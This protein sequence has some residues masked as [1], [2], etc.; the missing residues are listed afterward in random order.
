MGYFNR[1]GWLVELGIVER[2]PMRLPAAAAAAGPPVWRVVYATQMGAAETL[3]HETAEHIRQA[4]AEARVLA[5][6][7]LTAAS[8]ASAQ[9][10][11]LIASTTY[12]GDPPDMAEDFAAHAMRQPAQLAGLRF[13][14]LALGDRAYADFCAFGR[15]LHQWLLASGAQPLFAPIEVDDE[16][17]AALLAWQRRVGEQVALSLQAG[18]QAEQAR[19]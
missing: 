13:G 2:P 6:D 16:D 4:G 12:D 7:A 5:F 8:L 18:P 17:P 3:A 10:T 19:G 11:L 15:E 9:P 1:T 14:L